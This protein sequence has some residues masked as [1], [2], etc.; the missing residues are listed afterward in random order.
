MPSPFAPY[1][2]LR[3][4]F[5]R[6]SAAIPNFR[7]GSRVPTEIVVIDAWARST[8]EGGGEQ[9]A[10]GLALGSFGLSGF[11]VR[12]AILPP[13]SDWLSL[14]MTWEWTETGL[15]PQG[16]QAGD[17]LQACWGDLSGLPAVDDAEMGWLTLSQISHPYGSGGIGAKLRAA[18]GDKF[19][20]VFSES[21]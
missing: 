12:Y 5:E 20:G 16:L 13:G 10:G 8:S 19:A 2:N 6:R 18:A 17:K 9:Q 15:R 14:G 1:A 21:R 4:R 7:D 11:L 3:L